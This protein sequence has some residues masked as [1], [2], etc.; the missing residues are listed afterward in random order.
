MQRNGVVQVIVLQAYLTSAYARFIGSD[1]AHPAGF[2]RARGMMRRIQ[3][4]DRA[5]AHGTCY[6]CAMHFLHHSVMAIY[7]S[8]HVGA[9][10][11]DAGSILHGHVERAHH[12]DG[13]HSGPNLVNLFARLFEFFPFYVVHASMKFDLQTF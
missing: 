9:A 4:Q 11:L 6:A 10:H 2:F 3:Y 8:R 13:N 1:S 5:E 7:C 12:A